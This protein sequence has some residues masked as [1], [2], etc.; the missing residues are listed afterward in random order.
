[1]I[2]KDPDTI[3]KDPDKIWKDPSRILLESTQDSGKMY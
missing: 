2:W 3:W 1:M